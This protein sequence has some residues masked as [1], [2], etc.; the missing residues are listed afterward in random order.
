MY[1]VQK[2]EVPTGPVPARS[3]GCW[4]V[5]VPAVCG[6]ALRL[7]LAWRVCQRLLEMDGEVWPSSAYLGLVGY[8]RIPCI[9]CTAPS[10]NELG[11]EDVLWNYIFYWVLV[12]L[13]H[14]WFSIVYMH[15][16][17]VFVWGDKICENH[18]EKQKG[19]AVTQSLVKKDQMS[20]PLCNK[21]LLNSLSACCNESCQCS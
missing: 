13:S 11:K 21:V 20:F 8:W 3:L 2:A 10:G 19:P 1:W 18:V 15:T 9:L 14:R 5:P 7:L 16:A 17:Q 12:L 4:Q 6:C